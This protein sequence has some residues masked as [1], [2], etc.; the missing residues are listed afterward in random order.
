MTKTDRK[1]LEK[2]YTKVD[3]YAKLGTNG[4]IDYCGYIDEVTTNRQLY[5]FQY[6]LE[7]KYQINDFKM[8]YSDYKSEKLFNIIRS[9]TISRFQEDIYKLYKSNN[10]QQQGMNI[11]QSGTLIG[12]F[13]EDINSTLTATKINGHSSIFSDANTSLYDKYALGLNYLLS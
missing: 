10:I 5:I 1:R 9:K 8:S 11:Y 4:F 6:M 12:T 3:G 7:R 13:L 2:I